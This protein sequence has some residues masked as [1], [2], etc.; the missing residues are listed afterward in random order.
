[1]KFLKPRKNDLL[2]MLSMLFD[3][4]LSVSEVEAA[5]GDDY[6]AV[7]VDENEMPG[8]VVLCD[9]AFATYAGAALS[10]MHPEVAKEALAEPEL[11]QP[12]LDNL[13]EIM[14]ICT[15]L[16]ISESTPHLRLQSVGLVADTKA[17]DTISGA[18][19]RGDYEVEI[20]TYGIGSLSFLVT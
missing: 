13:H 3:G 17:V 9:R 8:A 2:A 4:N 14:N 11:S 10:M 16:I 1:M 7:Y 15:G 20:P 5:N 12:I 18:A 19:D 6:A